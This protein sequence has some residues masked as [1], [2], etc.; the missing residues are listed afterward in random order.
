MRCALWPEACAR[1]AAEIHSFFAGALREPAA[2]FIAENDG[3]RVCGFV[4]LS[5]RAD[6]PGFKGE[7]AGYVE[8]L[9]VSPE[10]RGRNVGKTLLQVS[11]G[12]ARQ[13]GCTMF[14]SDRAERIIID[15]KFS[16]TP[17]D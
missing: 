14:A 8:G 2:V 16:N 5:I 17:A 7:Q 10:A 11:R 15:R 12:W 6:L 9:Y 3:G 1:H 4:E 13:Q